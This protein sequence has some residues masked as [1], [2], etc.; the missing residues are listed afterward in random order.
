MGVGEE[1]ELERPAGSASFGPRCLKELNASLRT[2][3][4]GFEEIQELEAKS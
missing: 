3:R 1:K 4:Y 2:G